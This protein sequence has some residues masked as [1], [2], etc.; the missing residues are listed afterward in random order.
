MGNR[1]AGLAA[2]GASNESF[3]CDLG[4]FGVSPG[5]RG[6]AWGTV[7]PPDRLSYVT[8]TMGFEVLPLSLRVASVITC[9]PR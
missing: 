4:G 8:H 5:R 1:R 3:H 7:E 2:G 6:F 9:F